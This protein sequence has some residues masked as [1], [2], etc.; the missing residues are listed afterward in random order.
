MFPLYGGQQMDELGAFRNLS[1]EI[2]DMTLVELDRLI[3]N[4]SEWAHLTSE[5]QAAAKSRFLAIKRERYLLDRQA[6][7]AK[8]ADEA[9]QRAAV[10]VEEELQRRREDIR[11]DWEEAWEAERS[12][13]DKRELYQDHPVAVSEPE[14][15]LSFLASVIFLAMFLVGLFWFGQ[16]LLDA[17]NGDK[18]ATWPDALAYTM[19]VGRLPEQIQFCLENSWA[20]DGTLVLHWYVFWPFMFCLLVFAL[21]WIGLSY[22]KFADKT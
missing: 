2:S 17:W 5:Q 21:G 16:F 14:G 3:Q 7:A 19:G 6:A 11:L 1:S 10:A 12:A 4:Q 22:G 9:N 15:G 13:L 20:C 8:L 18:W